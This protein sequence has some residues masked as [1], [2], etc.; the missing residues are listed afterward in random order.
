MATLVGNRYAVWVLL[1]ERGVDKGAD[2][3]LH[4]R[5]PTVS[6]AARRHLEQ[7]WPVEDPMPAEI[8]EAIEMY[9]Q[10][11]GVAEHVVVA[12]FSIEGH[13]FFDGDEDLR[14]RCEACGQPVTLA[15]ADDP[16]SWIHADDADDRAGHTAEVDSVDRQPMEGDIA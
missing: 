16:E 1:I 14:P 9:N 5:E 4:W 6:A 13:Q 12:P 3:S 2:L 11:P 10:L 15:D 8:Q 7:A